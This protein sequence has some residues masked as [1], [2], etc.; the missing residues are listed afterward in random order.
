MK[1]IW[2]KFRF[3][4]FISLLIMI[5]GYFFYDYMFAHEALESSVTKYP[6][7]V[8]N[9]IYKYTFLGI[10]GI[11]FL[12]VALGMRTL[13]KFFKDIWILSFRLYGVWWIIKL[14]I[15]FCLSPVFLVSHVIHS[16]FKLFSVKGND[17]V[18]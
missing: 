10:I 14:F 18:F 5:F 16:L 17:Y 9:V 11:W 4:L 6:F 12:G 7:I 3:P 15:S 8:E 1:Y 2:K 13:N